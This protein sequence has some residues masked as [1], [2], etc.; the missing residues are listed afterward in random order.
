MRD[1][2]LSSRPE[3]FHLQAALPEPCMTLGPE[4]V[5]CADGATRIVQDFDVPDAAAAAE[6]ACSARPLACARASRA[7]NDALRCAATGSAA[8]AEVVHEPPPE[9]TRK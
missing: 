8:T 5:D 6:Q 3:D 2:L 7:A 1:T 9:T 4:S